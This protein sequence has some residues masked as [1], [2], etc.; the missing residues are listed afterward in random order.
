M[1]GLIQL[2]HKVYSNIPPDGI[3]STGVHPPFSKLF[4]DSVNVT[5]DLSRGHLIVDGLNGLGKFSQSLIESAK[6]NKITIVNMS[7]SIAWVE[8]D[9]NFLVFAGHFNKL[10][11]RGGRIFP[12]GFGVSQEAVDFSDQYTLL[13]RDSGI[14]RNFRPSMGQSV[15]NALDLALLPRLS[16]HF[17][18]TDSITPP[19][20]YISDLTTHKSCLVYGGD[21]YRDLRLNPWFVDNNREN[22][23]NFQTLANEPVIFRFDSW[24]FYEAALFGCCPIA[25]DLDR[26]GLDTSANPIPWLEYIPLDFSRLDEA[27]TKMLAQTDADPMYFERLGESARKWVI[28][29]H[30]P[31]AVAERVLNVM[32]SQGYL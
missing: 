11:K 7:D 8:H 4:R 10:A 13:K 2:G 17:P 20:R 16:N 27:I 32:E 23:L 12:I 25:L 14:L 9:E 26:Y 5:S 1:Q 29:H 6:K 30:S 21:F 15:R 19:E 31:K 18:I 28:N 24:R 22:N 3:K